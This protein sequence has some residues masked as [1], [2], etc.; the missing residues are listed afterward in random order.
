M[1]SKKITFNNKSILLKIVNVILVSV[2][3]LGAPML[4]K[5]ITN[6]FDFSSIDPDGSFMWITTRHIVQ[7]L[8]VFA[9][10]IVLSKIFPLNF[11]LGLGNRKVGLSYM[12][13]FMF[14]F[15]IYIP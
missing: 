5:L 1:F 14:F 8:I 3:L 15:V 10:V 13:R 9:F 12:S 7:A 6:M 2:I 11:N 4:A